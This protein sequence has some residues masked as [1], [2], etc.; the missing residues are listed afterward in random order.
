LLLSAKRSHFVLKAPSTTLEF[1]LFAA[2]GAEEIR[3]RTVVRKGCDLRV[4]AVRATGPSADPGF[5]PRAGVL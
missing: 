1:E 5:C 2:K 4:A 3:E